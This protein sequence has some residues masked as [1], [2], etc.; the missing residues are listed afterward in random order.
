MKKLK[1]FL[2]MAV[3][4]LGASLTTVTA[5][6]GST[7]NPRVTFEN[8]Q[9]KQPDLYVTKT[10]T[11][12]ESG[13]TIPDAE[14][15]FI[16]EWDLDGDGILSYAANEKYYLYE[17]DGTL[18]WADSDTDYFTTDAYGRF[19]LKAG[20]TA[21]F[22]Y[23]GKNVAYQITEEAVEYF[24]QT[25]PAG[26]MPAAGTVDEDGTLVEFVNTYIPVIPSDDPTKIVVYKSVYYPTGYEA[27]EFDDT[28]TFEIEI[29]G[30]AY[31]GEAYIVYDSDTDEEIGSYYTDDTTGKKGQFTLKAGQYAVFED[32]PKNA[33]YEIREILDN[34][35]KW[36]LVSSD[37]TE[38]AAAYPGTYVY[39]TNSTASFIAAKDMY[40][41]SSPDD[42]FTFTVTDENDDPIANLYYYLYDE[43]KNLVQADPLYTDANGQFTL[44]TGQ[45]AVFVGLPVDTVYTVTENTAANYKVVT[46]E[47]G[48]YEDQ[49]VSE[50]AQTLGFV[51]TA[52]TGSLTIYKYGNDG[53]TL[54]ENA[55]FELRKTDGTLVGFQTTGTDGK[56]TFTS[57][58]PGT[59]V[60]TETKTEENYTLLSEALEITIPLSMTEDE[61]TAQGVDTGKAVAVTSNGE[62]TYYFYNL[63]Y[64]ITN[65]ATLDLPTTGG[66][67]VLTAALVLGAVM[68]LAGGLLLRRRKRRV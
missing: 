48:A 62:T 44:K 65:G 7:D 19:T 56:V 42:D 17:E 49:T 21:K 66:H 45:K 8:S 47:S 25:T 18:V 54:L 29:D 40:D 33:D 31:A 50:T 13:Y 52:Y 12:A 60:L 24:T 27:P 39:F 22:E 58:L 15:T 63:T 43:D 35:S 11:A 53:Q 64:N 9:V 5:E 37:N 68:V 4:L 16:L 6:A 59:Y 1:L 46:P 10:V 67:F 20:Q 38:G 3:L 28:F 57:L 51:N 14:F 32:I 36:T 2:T 41:G 61:A 34:G 26:G 23:V 55:A 30:E